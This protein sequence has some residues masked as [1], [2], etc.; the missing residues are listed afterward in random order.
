MFHDDDDDIGRRFTEEENAPSFG[1]V[2]FKG[3]ICEEGEAP[4]TWE[5]NV[6][7]RSSVDA[8]LASATLLLIHKDRM[9]RDFYEIMDMHSDETSRLATSIFTDRGLIRPKLISNPAERGSGVWGEEINNGSI[10]LVEEIRVLEQYRR[11]GLGRW[12]L[13]KIFTIPEIA[14]SCLFAYA[15]PTVLNQDNDCPDSEREARCSLIVRFFHLAGFRRV[16]RTSFVAYAIHDPNHPSRNLPMEQDPPRLDAAPPAL[17]DDQLRAQYPLHHA[18]ATFTDE[19]AVQLIHASPASS[20]HTRDWAGHTLLHIAAVTGKVQAVRELLAVGGPQDLTATTTQGLTPLEQLRAELADTRQFFDAMVDIPWTGYEKEKCIILLE[21][22]RAMGKPVPPV[23]PGAEPWTALK[24]G[25]TCG[26]CS[27]GWLSPQMR[28]RLKVCAEVAS[29]MVREEAD[30]LPSHEPAHDLMQPMT[31]CIPLPIRQA[32][33]YPSYLKGLAIIFSAITYSLEADSAPSVET[34]KSSIPHARFYSAQHVQ[35]YFSHGG[36]VEH[37][38][39]GII[40]HSFEEGP[41][42]DNS[43]VDVPEFK[44]DLDALPTCE[45][46]DGHAQVWALLGLPDT[47]RHYRPEYGDDDDED[48]D[49]EDLSDFDDF[50]GGDDDSDEDEDDDDDY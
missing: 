5:I 50:D 1:R 45:N 39:Q 31:E 21:L 2:F 41:H 32:G 25:C 19:E 26:Q 24:W 28:Y 44:S 37:A 30:E 48:E 18:M 9:K 3:R 11:R 23:V 36:L 34:I 38:L 33:V 42:G 49:D 27:G 17:S 13:R 16:G 29:D 35:Y 46:D 8:P 14:N 10:L 47:F 12:L 7:V 15:W 6:E 22:C 43:F 20:L 40:S 4:H